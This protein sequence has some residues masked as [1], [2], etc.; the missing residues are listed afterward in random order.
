MNKQNGNFINDES[1]A[2]QEILFKTKIIKINTVEDEI[3]YIQSFR[4]KSSWN[5]LTT[6]SS[7][8]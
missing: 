2:V 8:N 1:S 5:F 4:N 7:M 3:I 6:M